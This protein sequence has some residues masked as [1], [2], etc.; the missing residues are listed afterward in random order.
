MQKYESIERGIANND[1]VGLREAIGSICYT[2]RDFSSGEFDEVLRYVESKGIKLKD[3][4]LDGDL[5][6]DGKTAYTDEDFAR[7]V[8][9]LK[10]NFCKERIADVKKI[11]KALTCFCTDI[12]NWYKPKKSPKPS[13]GKQS[14]QNTS[15]GDRSGN[16]TNRNNNSS[17]SIPVKPKNSFA[18]RNYEDVRRRFYCGD[19]KYKRYCIECSDLRKCKQNPTKSLREWGFLHQKDFEEFR[20]MGLKKN[21]DFLKKWR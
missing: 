8:F 14:R 18:V 6:S 2:S 4:T 5:I 21:K 10:K 11:G 16:H 13:G 12:A 1:I 17:D 7:A 9:M 19:G 15:G 20:K 3:D